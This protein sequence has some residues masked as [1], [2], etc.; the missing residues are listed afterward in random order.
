MLRVIENPRRPK[1]YMVIDENYA[2]IRMPRD[3]VPTRSAALRHKYRLEIEDL[4]LSKCLNKVLE[5]GK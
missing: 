4:N 1:T 3:A 2:E 5:T